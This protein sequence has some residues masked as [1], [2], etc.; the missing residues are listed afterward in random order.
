M[1]KGVFIYFCGQ[2]IMLRRTI[3]KNPLTESCLRSWHRAGGGTFLIGLSGGAD[4]TALAL[5]FLEAGVPFEAAHCNFHLRGEES[6]RDRNFVKSLCDTFGVTMHEVDFNVAEEAQRGE[7]VEMTCRRIRYDYFRQLMAEGNFRR[8]A[9]AHNADDNIETFFLNALRGSGTRGLKGMEEDNGEV[10]RP[11]LKFHRSEILEF[12]RERNQL[13]VTDSSNLESD[14]YRRNFLRNEVFPLM[15]KRWEGFGSA[16][17]RTIE[18]QR[19]ENAI[20]EHFVA[21]ALDGY[22][23]FIPWYVVFDFPD[24]ET[25]IYRFIEPIGG[26]PT[27]A[28]E[29]AESAK[30]LIP[31]KI[32]RFA[33]VVAI[34]T[35]DGIRIKKGAAKQNGHKEKVDVSLNFDWE[36]IPK[37]KIDW[38]IVKTAPLSEIYLPYDSSRYEWVTATRE[39]KI[40]PLGMQGSQSVWK[41]L[42][43]AGIPLLDR[44]QFPVLADRDSGEPVWLPGVK[45][46]RL[47]LVTAENASLFHV[48]S[49]NDKKG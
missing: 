47:H 4:S 41:V 10:V 34:F 36:E 49:P 11:L 2:D 27:I 43:D 30:Q 14:H 8:L 7:S 24:S 26:T 12:L 31:G 6:D 18:L 20:V 48:Y 39:M 29:M 21:K 35:K 13:Y 32:W 40:K 1:R 16:L 19:R 15:A 9:V 38:D 17:T 23:D 3:G 42:K 44:S 28:R 45:R 5:A 37:E 33:D 22:T 25:L 46:S